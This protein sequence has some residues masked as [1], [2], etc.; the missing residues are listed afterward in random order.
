MTVSRNRRVPLG[1][2]L[3][4]D[5]ATRQL[6][7]CVP[8]LARG[9]GA[10]QQLSVSPHHSHPKVLLRFTAVLPVRADASASCVAYGVAFFHP[11]LGADGEELPGTRSGYRALTSRTVRSPALTCGRW[12]RTQN[13]SPLG[14]TGEAIE[15]SCGCAH[16]FRVRKK[17]PSI[18]GGA[19]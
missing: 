6:C 2:D 8:R 14:A 3:P 10:H 12:R 7:A 11:R 16:E 1:P 9:T 19:L 4:D 18:V 5:I 13:S 15:E 17:Q